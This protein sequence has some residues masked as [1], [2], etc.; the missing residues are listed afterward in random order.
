MRSHVISKVHSM[1]DLILL[2]HTSEEKSDEARIRSRRSMRAV[3]FCRRSFSCFSLNVKL[4]FF[5]LNT[6]NISRLYFL[7]Q[8]RSLFY[9]WNGSNSP[10]WLQS[11]FYNQFIVLFSLFSMTCL[12]NTKKVVVLLME[13]DNI[14]NMSLKIYTTSSQKLLK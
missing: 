10:F 2:R 1:V 13:Y 5:H 8:N 14:S 4:L 12:G 9:V 11:G 6:C 3:S 7:F